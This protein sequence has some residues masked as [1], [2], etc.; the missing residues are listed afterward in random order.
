MFKLPFT[1]EELSDYFKSERIFNQRS[2]E[3]MDFEQFKKAFFPF[4]AAQG[5]E[6]DFEKRN[7]QRMD[8]ILNTKDEK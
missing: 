8:E 2:D 7:E 3:G 5:M 6:N 1:K 4:R